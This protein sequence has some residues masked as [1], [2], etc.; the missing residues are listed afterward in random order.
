MVVQSILLL[1]AGAAI[2]LAADR[3][4]W[5]REDRV[6]WNEERR[7]IY[8]RFL[9]A[10]D[11]WRELDWVLAMEIG[12][13]DGSDFEHAG[14]LVPVADDSSVGGLRLRV[15]AASERVMTALADMELVAST[16]ASQAARAL[17]TRAREV[18]AVAR[19]FPP[20]HC[21]GVS[22][23]LMEADEQLGADR[24]DFVA[25]VRRE[26]GVPT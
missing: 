19:D 3:L 12:L 18:G 6:R 16:D 10:L 13:E 5:R 9:V 7:E 24:L 4:R 23:P 2:A 26:L 8:K 21:G 15:G 14:Y 25:R 17:W 1:I 20:R 22:E 11:E